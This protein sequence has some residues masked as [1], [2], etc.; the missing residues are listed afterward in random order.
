MLLLLENGLK[1][2][3]GLTLPPSFVTFFEVAKPAENVELLRVTAADPTARWIQ[4]DAFPRYGCF[5]LS[6]AWGG[7]NR[8]D[9]PG[10]FFFFF[11]ILF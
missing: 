1:S 8:S 9:Y 5:V 4:F 10:T 7:M 6:W 2:S 3:N 11:I